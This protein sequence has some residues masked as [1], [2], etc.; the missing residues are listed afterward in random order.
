MAGPRIPRGTR[1]TAATVTAGWKIDERSRDRWNAIAARSGISAAA[2]FD[3]MVESI[4][5][6]GPNRPSWLPD[7]PIA[8]DGVLPIDAA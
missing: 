8:G 5:V 2:L 3:R 7:D 4:E 1:G 6:D